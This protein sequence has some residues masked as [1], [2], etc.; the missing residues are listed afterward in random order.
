MAG[1][2]AGEAE[3]RELEAQ[4]EAAADAIRAAVLRLLKEGEVD[5]RLV[6]LA[7]AR[8][9]GE[10]GAAAALAGGEDA[11]QVLGGLAE[12]VRQAGRE[13]YE[14]LRGVTL[15]VAGSA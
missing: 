9:A 2:G 8:V 14:V 4:A 13:H 10:L 7:A 11:G 15:P 12:V 5:L 1:E 3:G 6:V